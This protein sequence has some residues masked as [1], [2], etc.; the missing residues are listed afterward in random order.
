MPSKLF[1]LD[2]IVNRKYTKGLL[3]HEIMVSLKHFWLTLEREACLEKNSECGYWH[4]NLV[5]KKASNVSERFLFPEE[6]QAWIK[7]L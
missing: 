1:K 3:S 6:A 5:G 7:R 4:I 2:K